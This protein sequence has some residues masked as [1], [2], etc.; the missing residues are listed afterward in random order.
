VLVLRDSRIESA[1][2]KLNGGSKD[3]SADANI[4]DLDDLQIRKVQDGTNWIYEIELRAKTET[5]EMIPRA[6]W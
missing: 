3:K 2:K 5:G 1:F 4:V 6:L